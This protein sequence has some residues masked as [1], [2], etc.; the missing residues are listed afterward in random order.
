MFQSVRFIRG[1]LTVS[2]WFLIRLKYR[3]S[4]SNLIRLIWFYFFIFHL[5]P[6]WI[7]VCLFD[8]C[9]W[10]CSTIVWYWI[11]GDTVGTFATGS[12]SLCTLL[13]CSWLQP[14]LMVLTLGTINLLHV[15]NL[16]MFC[17]P[18][19]KPFISCGPRSVLVR[20]KHCY[21]G[22]RGQY[23]E[24]VEMMGR[25]SLGPWQVSTWLGS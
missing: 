20:I 14:F 1:F 16:R 12:A 3:T 9:W 19:S 7:F 25:P 4:L 18:F 15:L 11:S 8:V 13:I 6:F 17:H 24:R 21:V 22:K 23:P 10:V 2:V 5:V